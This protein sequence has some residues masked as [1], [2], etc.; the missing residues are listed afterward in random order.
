MIQRC[1]SQV[2]T[3][4]YHYYL[5]LIFRIRKQFHG[6]YIF[7]SAYFIVIGIK[8]IYTYIK[9]KTFSLEQIIT[10]LFICFLLQIDTLAAEYPSVTNYLYVTYNGQVGMGKLA[11]PESTRFGRQFTLGNIYFLPLWI[12]R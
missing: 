4:P 3:R 2:I 5:S 9:Q 7:L 1:V 10:F 11:Y 6:S 12:S 8:G